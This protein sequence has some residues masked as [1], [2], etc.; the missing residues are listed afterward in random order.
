MK[1]SIGLRFY[2][3]RMRDN[4]EFWVKCCRS[5]AISKRGQGR[6]KAPLIQELA[7]AP[8]RRVAFDVIGPCPQHIVVND[9]Y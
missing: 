6:G 7:G 5:F 4:I 3:L 1:S 8:V 2:W 9:L